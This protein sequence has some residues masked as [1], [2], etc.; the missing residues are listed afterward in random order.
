LSSQ[1]DR[2]VYVSVDEPFTASIYSDILGDN[3]GGST[4]DWLL[5]LA[6][7]ALD[8]A[9][10]GTESAQM[11]LLITDD[12]TIRTLNAQYRGVDEVTDVLSFSA[13][14]PGHWEG[15]TEPPEDIGGVDFVMPPGEPSPLGEV[16]VSYSQ[17][18]RQA[19]ERGAPLE[20]ELAL[21]VVHGVLHLTGHDHLDPE[22]AALMQSKERQAL[23][24]L[25]IRS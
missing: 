9:L 25:D 21:L 18:Q 17:A 3:P 22:D 2:Q 20:H 4:E 13:E 23:A 1:H 15:E 5:G 11:S 14:H 10:E 16:I 8:V 7:A 12:G 24:T 6:K 19:E